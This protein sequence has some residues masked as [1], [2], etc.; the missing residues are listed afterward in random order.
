VEGLPNRLRL[1]EWKDELACS[2]WK[3][4]SACTHLELMEFY[5]LVKQNSNTDSMCC[6]LV[7]IRDL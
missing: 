7:V 4:S 1:P 3:W 2:A 5:A 6:K